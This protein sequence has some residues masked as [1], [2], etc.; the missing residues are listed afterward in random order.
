MRNKIELKNYQ[1]YEFCS[2]NRKTGE[3][4]FYKGKK[5]VPG[6]TGLY[7]KDERSFFAI[8]PT[9]LGP[10]IYYKGKE[11]HINKDLSISLQKNDDKRKFYINNYNIEINYIQSPYIGFDALSDEIDVDLFYMIEQRYRDDEFYDQYTLT[12][13]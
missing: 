12:S 13:E 9:K 2:L 7:F 8:Y 3:T 10:Q 1:I 6:F 4:D 5:K 11:Y